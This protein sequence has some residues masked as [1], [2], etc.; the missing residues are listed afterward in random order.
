MSVAVDRLPL[1]P[2]GALVAF[3][4]QAPRATPGPCGECRARV[5][6]RGAHPE[7]LRVHGPA[8]LAPA[9]TAPAQADPLALAPADERRLLALGARILG[10]PDL[11]RDALQEALV[12]LWQEPTR[13]ANVPAWLG[14]AMLHRTLHARRTR[15]RRAA[16]EEQAGR[17]TW[18]VRAGDDPAGA[19]ER[20]EARA[21]I[22]AAVAT[23][24]PE[25]RGAF[26]LRE[27]E[28]LDYQAIA[29]R[30]GVPVGTVRSRIHR[31]R[32]RLADLLGPLAVG[33]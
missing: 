29:A 14:R 1:P 31:A 26:V 5:E 9:R 24:P 6:R 16:H 25:H 23:L 28:G 21:R 30:L 7:G 2:R 19:L 11:A 27:A 22:D 17:A 3:D 33:A 8:Q 4:P 13:P 32:A 12:S 20:A 15:A 10:C 18:N